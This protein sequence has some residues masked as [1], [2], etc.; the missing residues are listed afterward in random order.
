[1]AYIHKYGWIAWP[2]TREFPFPE[3]PLFKVQ[4]FFCV[5]LRWSQ[6]IKRS[7]NDQKLGK[8]IHWIMMSTYVKLRLPLKKGSGKRLHRGQKLETET[9]ASGVLVIF[10]Y[11]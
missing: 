3:L 1:M 9:T 11:L 10:P 7:K 4:I 2:L 5:E 8:G 6:Y